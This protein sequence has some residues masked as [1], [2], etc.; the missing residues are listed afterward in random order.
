MNEKYKEMLAKY[1][2]RKTSYGSENQ[3]LYNATDILICKKAV[4]DYEFCDPSEFDDIIENDNTTCVKT[5]LLWLIDYG[6]EKLGCTRIKYFSIFTRDF[7]L[8]MRFALAWIKAY[9]KNEENLNLPKEHIFY[10]M[11][12]ITTLNNKTYPWYDRAN[13]L[14]INRYGNPLVSLPDYAEPLTTIS[15]KLTKYCFQNIDSD[16]FS[17][18]K[19]NIP[20]LFSMR[21]ARTNEKKDKI[22][23]LELALYKILYA[24]FP[25]EI[26]RHAAANGEIV[27]NAFLI[28][29]PILIQELCCLSVHE[30]LPVLINATDIDDYGDDL[31]KYMNDY[32]DNVVASSAPEFEIFRRK[33]KKAYNRYANTLNKKK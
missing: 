17:K 22:N 14:S 13:V 18:A 1:D 3:Q 24:A 26:L 21:A 7:P 20:K 27:S 30:N 31:I 10:Y 19:L 11:L 29:K 6:V 32:A 8:T 25:D 28:P 16:A 9:A 33:F 4:E 2:N 23:S 15:M 5:A 12:S